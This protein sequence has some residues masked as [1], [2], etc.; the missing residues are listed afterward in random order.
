M[1]IFSPGSLIDERLTWNEIDS[2]SVKVTFHNGKYTVSAILYFNEEGALINFVSNDRYALQDDGTM[3][4]VQWTTPVS[5]YK[6]L[7]GRKI[8]FSG[9]TIWNYPEGD[10]TY[11]VFRLRSIKF[12][13]SN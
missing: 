6:E 4:Q 3:K 10:F 9:K 2:L 11:G 13:V 12:N 1:C 8:P 7:E 5:D